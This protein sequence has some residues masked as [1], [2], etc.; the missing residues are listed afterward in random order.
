MMFVKKNQYERRGNYAFLTLSGNT[1]LS[2]KNRPILV[3]FGKLWEPYPISMIKLPIKTLFLMWIFTLNLNPTSKKLLFP[4]FE[5]V[6]TVD[7]W[8]FRKC[9]FHDGFSIKR[10]QWQ[11][12]INI[13][14]L[15]SN[16]MPKKL[17]FTKKSL[18]LTETRQN[19]AN[20][21]IEA[22]DHFWSVLWE[23]VKQLINPPP[24]S[25]VFL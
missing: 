3:V 10:L 16:M 4:F 14:T 5:K 21:I 6:S 2:G 19:L 12:F 22:N 15:N 7:T 1:P 23:R 25:I 17:S 18:F 13:L 20:L 8:P 11:F 24:P 9:R